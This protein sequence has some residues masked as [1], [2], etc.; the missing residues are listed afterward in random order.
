MS[1]YPPSKTHRGTYY[2]KSLPLSTHPTYSIDVVS[3][4]TAAMRIAFPFCLFIFLTSLVDAAPLPVPITHQATNYTCGPA[5]LVSVLGYY[6]K[7]NTNESQLAEL[8]NTTQA[9]TAILDLA[10]V[11][12]NQGVLADFRDRLTWEDL[13]AVNRRG[14]LSIVAIQAWGDDPTAYRS[15]W[16]DGHYVVVV[17]MDTEKIYF[18]DPFMIGGHASLTR[19]EFL[20][21]WHDELGDGTKSQ[22]PGILFK[23]L[24]SPPMEWSPIL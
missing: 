5:A 17:G 9:G 8:A 21:R 15:G 19:T 3:V 10:R 22:H 13:E 16:S 4:H 6:G 20:S 23:G 11:A 7:S 1:C 2:G 14:D 18:M 24:P 12:N